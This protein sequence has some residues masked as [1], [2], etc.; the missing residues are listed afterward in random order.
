MDRERK[1]ESAVSPAIAFAASSR[2]FSPDRATPPHARAKHASPIRCN[3][4]WP[5][6]RA[7][8]SFLTLRP[9]SP[10]Q[11]AFFLPYT[12]AGSRS[13]G[14]STGLGT[15]RGR[16]RIGRTAWSNSVCPSRVMSRA[17]LFAP[18]LFSSRLA[19]TKTPFYS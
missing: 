15:R 9:V 6:T 13:R 18:R 1:R 4:P 19:L 3:E 16:R 2:F 12:R 8:L 5:Q 11:I 10:Q 14:K 7:C 17:A